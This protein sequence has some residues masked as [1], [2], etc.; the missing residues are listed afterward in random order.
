MLP[1]RS[2]SIVDLAKQV[3][4]S[5][6]RP[7]S[8]QWPFQGQVTNC[9]S[10]AGVVLGT[11][12]PEGTTVWQLVEICGSEVEVILGGEEG[13]DLDLSRLSRIELPGCD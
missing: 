3:S 8:F 10:L 5:F 6:W 13:F 4:G 1:S 2:D 9:E 7:L 11:K 12:A